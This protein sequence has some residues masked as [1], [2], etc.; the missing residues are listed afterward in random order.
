VVGE[1]V[2]S[3]LVPVVAHPLITA[4][5]TM[6][7][8]VVPRRNAGL[9]QLSL[10]ERDSAAVTTEIAEKKTERSDS[11]IST[12]YVLNGIVRSTA[13]ERP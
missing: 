10:A 3:P 5:K 11:T 6:T 8:A 4:A 12:A 1:V 2:R 13:S 9:P 7:V